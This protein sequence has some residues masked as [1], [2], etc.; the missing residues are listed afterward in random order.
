MGAPHFLRNGLGHLVNLRLINL[1][2]P[3]QELHSLTD[4]C[5]RVALEGSF[6]A[7]IALSASAALPSEIVAIGSSL[8]GLMTLKSQALVGL[9]HSPSI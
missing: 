1:N 5:L 2:D 3:L 8:A 4:N 6:R 7:A 9:T